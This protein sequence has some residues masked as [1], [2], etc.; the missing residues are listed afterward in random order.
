[1]SEF[2]IVDKKAVFEIRKDLGKMLDS[3]IEKDYPY[4]EVMYCLLQMVRI[5]ELDSKS[6]LTNAQKELAVNEAERIYCNFFKCS[7]C[8]GHEVNYI[9]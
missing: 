9:E 5:M 8:A 1:M 6:K 2:H 7:F 3:F 4:P